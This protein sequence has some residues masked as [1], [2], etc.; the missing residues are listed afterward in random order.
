MALRDKFENLLINCQVGDYYSPIDNFMMEQSR[1]IL[2]SKKKREFVELIPT[3]IH[4][5][6]SNN[7]SWISLPRIEAFSGFC[8][9]VRQGIYSTDLYDRHLLYSMLLSRINNP[10]IYNDELL[11]HLASLDLFPSDITL[12]VEDM[13]RVNLDAADKYIQLIKGTI[14]NPKLVASIFY[15][16]T[17]SCNY[18]EEYGN[19]QPIFRNID[20]F[21]DGMNNL[22]ELYSKVDKD[23]DTQ[24]KV[25]QRILADL[26]SVLT[27]IPINQAVKLIELCDKE[28]DRKKV[29]DYI[30]DHFDE[31]TEFYSGVSL[32]DVL[33]TDLQGIP[34]LDKKRRE[35][36]NENFEDLIPRMF[37]QGA[38][39]DKEKEAAR[40]EV[41]PVLEILF[42]ELC[43]NEGVEYADI[44]MLGEGHFTKVFQVGEKVIKIGR[45]RYTHKFPNNPYIVAM[46]LRRNIELPKENIFIEITEMVD[47]VDN[48]QVG[49]EELYELYSKMRAIGLEWMDIEARNVGR[50]RRD[51]IIYW[52]DGLEPTDE[53]L[54]LDSRVGE[55]IV[56]KAGDLVIIDSDF[57]Y[58]TGEIPRKLIDASE[59]DRWSFMTKWIAFKK[60]YD[61]EHSIGER[62]KT[63]IYTRFTKSLHENN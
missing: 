22:Y 55:D 38:R 51:N 29:I 36:V 58:R 61:K 63:K 31:L 35:F 34:E 14:K 33:I 8:E 19:Y 18:Y 16:I 40:K 56:L 17:C 52:K 2:F 45:G 27:R 41:K 4:Y 5:S 53:S 1:G 50:L 28:E 25:R 15:S 3:V 37:F 48:K 59:E 9:A 12:L 32:F 46:L 20:F 57:I 11:A 39:Y 10:D 44:S 60:R 21:M 49:D 62:P 30:K 47:Q 54:G 13:C 7:I 23:K 42:D 43:Q 6:N 26:D 24:E